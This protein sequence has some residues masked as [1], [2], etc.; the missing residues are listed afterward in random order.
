V[1]VDTLSH[2]EFQYPGSWTLERVKASS[3]DSERTFG[4][5]TPDWDSTKVND[6]FEVPDY[7][8]EISVYEGT[9]DSTAERFGTFYENGKWWIEGRAGARDMGSAF[10]SPTWRGVRGVS[11]VGMYKKHEG[12]YLGA[13]S[14]LVAFLDN[15]KGKVV[16]I[17]GNWP[18]DDE[19]LFDRVLN[20]IRF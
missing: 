6:E 15:G 1:F 11:E 5:K 18:F 13:A 16:V 10:S 14:S 3:V 17:V 20:S 2:L 19:S 12:G 4:L 7:A 9:L 8:I